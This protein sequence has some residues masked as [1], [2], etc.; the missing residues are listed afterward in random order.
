MNR[1]LCVSRQGLVAVNH[2]IKNKAAMGMHKM[3]RDVTM[4][5]KWFLHVYTDIQLPELPINIQSTIVSDSTA[6]SHKSNRWV[7]FCLFMMLME[8]TEKTAATLSCGGLPSACVYWLVQLFPEVRH[9]EMQLAKSMES[10][11]RKGSLSR[12]QQSSMKSCRYTDKTCK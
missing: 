3:S 6:H 11:K 12:E 10:R 8:V 7:I 1:F 2:P 9:E 4:C 5:W